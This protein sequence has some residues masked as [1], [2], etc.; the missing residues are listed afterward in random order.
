VVAKDIVCMLTYGSSIGSNR[1]VTKVLGVD[2]KTSKKS[3]S[4][5]FQ[6]IQSTMHFGLLKRGQDIFTPCLHPSEIL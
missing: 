6:W 1:G 4:D 2:K 3:W 5:E